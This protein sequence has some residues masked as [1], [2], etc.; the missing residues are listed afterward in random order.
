[1]FGSI[2]MPELILIFIVALIVFGPRK[3]PEIGKSLGKGL[4]EFKKASEDLKKTIEHEIEEGKTE[5]NSVKTEVKAATRLGRPR[6]LDRPEPPDPP[7]LRRRI[8]APAT[9]LEPVPAGARQPA[10]RRRLGRAPADGVLRAPGGAAPPPHRLAPGALR[11]LPRLL[12]LGAGAV[13]PARPPGARRAAARPEPR[14]HDARRAVRPLLPRRDARRDDPG[15]AGDPLAGLAL[16]RAR[17]LQERAPLGVAVPLRRGLLL[18]LGL[19]L[20]LLRGVPARRRVPGRRRQA[21]PR[22]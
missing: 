19:R 6:G 5:V 8:P 14:L 2:G 18:P 3:L 4:A 22:R 15:V 9:P 13:R 11:R 10:P 1:M 21:V 17:S 7:N 16:R 20:R 12:V